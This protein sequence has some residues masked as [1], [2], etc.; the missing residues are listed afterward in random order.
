MFELLKWNEASSRGLDEVARMTLLFMV[1]C[2]GC[3][4]NTNGHTYLYLLMV[5]VVLQKYLYIFSNTY[6]FIRYF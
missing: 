4:R 3:E 1:A 6:L 5:T 2:Y